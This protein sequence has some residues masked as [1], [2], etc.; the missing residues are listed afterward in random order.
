M[1]TVVTVSRNIYTILGLGSTM[2][3]Y[4][5]LS[6]GDSEPQNLNHFRAVTC[7]GG[8]VDSVTAKDMYWWI[9]ILKDVFL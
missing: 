8:T 9:T 4:P 3:A 2:Q 6:Y 5:A 1:S 7:S